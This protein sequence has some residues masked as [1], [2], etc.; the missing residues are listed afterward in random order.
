MSPS[1]SRR[2]FTD[3]CLRA[4]TLAGSATLLRAGVAA[5]ASPARGKKG[6]TI[7]AFTK[8]FQSLGYD[9]L[10]DRIAELGFDGIEAPVRDGGHI[11]P[12]RVEEELP[13]LVEALKK[14]GLEITV[15]ASSVSRCDEPHTEKVLRTAASLG[16]RRYRMAHLRYD[17]ERPVLEQI[18][19]LRPQFKELAA[20]NRELGITGVYQ[21][22]AGSDY[23]GG[24][25]W[26][27]DRLLHDI[28]VEELGMAYDIRHA[29]VEGGTTWRVD[30]NLMRPHISVVYVKD[31]SWVDENVRNVPLGEGQ[32]SPEFFTILGKWGYAGPVSLHEEYLDHRDPAQVPSHLQA[33]RRDLARLRE[34][35][36]S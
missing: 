25:I 17:L 2:K 8:P 22:H 1:L 28:P 6:H 21:N 7:C 30:L 36:P 31:F 20:M 12:P 35:L 19:G 5:G 11:E 34:W 24:A 29:T 9:E 10:A 3:R 14:R 15:L 16:I 13:K 23:V 26:D 33:L 4:L 32:I 27:L 18:R